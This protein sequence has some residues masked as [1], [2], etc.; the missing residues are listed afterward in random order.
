MIVAKEHSINKV[1]S[2]KKLPVDSLVMWL[3]VNTPRVK[4]GEKKRIQFKM[5]VH[6]ELL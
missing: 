6:V 3:F 1:V 5:Q 4:T 2:K